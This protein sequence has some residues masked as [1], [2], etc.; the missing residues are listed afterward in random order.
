MSL[1]PHGHV[2]TV[3][4]S[5]RDFPP[6]GVGCE[7]WTAAV[8]AR[9]PYCCFAVYFILGVTSLRLAMP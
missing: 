7:G 5:N 4:L 9:G 2:V 8:S 3:A 6:E 1:L